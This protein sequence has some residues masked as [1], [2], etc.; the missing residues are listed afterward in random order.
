MKL[1]EKIKS[2]RNQNNMSQKDLA[3][4]LIVSPELVANW[5]AGDSS[6]DVDQILKLSVIFNV[7]TDYL[8]KSDSHKTKEVNT[9]YTKKRTRRISFLVSTIYSSAIVIFLILGFAFNLWHIGWVVFFLP[10]IITRF[11]QEFMS[12]NEEDYDAFEKAIE[13]EDD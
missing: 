9:Y 3:E 7:S 2:L 11:L 6:P 13:K 5:E 10:P 8:L 4:T 1:N 12:K